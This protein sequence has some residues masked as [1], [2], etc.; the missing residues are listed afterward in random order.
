MSFFMIPFF[1][2]PPGL[3]AAPWLI[4]EAFLCGPMYV[5]ATIFFLITFFAFIR[6]VFQRKFLDFDELQELIKKTRG[7]G[8][9]PVNRPNEGGPLCID[10]F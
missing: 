8:P 7:K 6:P 10:P 1:H 2:V 4:G 3:I 9:S 5:M